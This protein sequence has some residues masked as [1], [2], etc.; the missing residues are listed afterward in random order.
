MKIQFITTSFNGMA[1]RLWTELDRHN[2]EVHV[3]IFTTPQEVIEET[4]NYQP[5]LII[6][7][8]LNQ[9]IP[10]EIWKNYTTLI[11]HP[12]IKGDRGASSLDWAILR[13]EKQW[14]VTILEAVDKMD[15]GDIWATRNF[16]M[17]PSVTKSELYRCEVTQAAAQ[18]VLEAVEKF[19]N[20]NFKPEPLDYSNPE[21]KGRWNRKTREED[22]AF[23]WNE[24]TGNILRKIRAA[25][26]Q[27][28]ATTLIDGQKY[29]VF[30]AY[31]E[32]KLQ[33]KPGEIL[34]RRH[35]GICIATAD[36]ALWITQLRKP[37]PEAIKLPATM[38]LGERANRI[39]I[40][41]LSPFDDVSYQTWRDIRFEQDEE[42][43][44]IGYL[45]FDFY[46][47]AMSAGQCDR[48]R[49]TFIQAKEKAEIIVLTGGRDLWSNGIHLNIIEAAGNP[50]D[51]SWK[52]INAIDDLIKEIILTTD[53][54]IIA[55]LQGNAGAGGVS[56][57]LAADKIL[58][59]EGIVLNP[60]T[61]NMG[62]YGSEYW[63]Y[64]LPKRIGFEKAERITQDC[65]PWGV[66][67]LYEA[68]MIDGYHGQSP[69]EFMPYVRNEARKVARL[70][71]FDKLLKAK[72][73]QRMKDERNK[74]LEKY[75]EEELEQ[76]RKNFYEDN[77]N[78][79]ERRHCF[80]RKI[81]RPDVHLPENLYSARRKIFRR[82][83][84]ESYEYNGNNK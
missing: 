83:K 13:D 51:E 27:P 67:L 63:T 31:P 44:R 39:P 17:R 70:S 36:G 78:Y 54:Y 40:S 41:E 57:A 71:Y 75:R 37:E 6:A 68:G 10:E 24:P 55:A 73:F 4:R 5:N 65:L 7:P 60:H 15:A 46:N 81:F 45:H 21:I 16:K 74:P 42:E 23:S 82:R 50:A 32:E 20:R 11:V 48:L 84:W 59:R 25:D 2:H 72:K 66:H 79:N 47:G 56:L 19:E 3:V 14:G 62:L 8:Y 22:F 53:R 35:Y 26:S 76:M 1:Q 34:A 30:G 64:L 61:K 9:K 49:E 33:G 18:A 77:W 58:A 29:H 43:P 80:V 38:V 28:G 69:E 12:G 52:N